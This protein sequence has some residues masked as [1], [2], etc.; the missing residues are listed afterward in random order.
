[1][2]RW[3]AGPTAQAAQLPLPLAPLSTDR[4]RR[5]A[6]TAAARRLAPH[7]PPLLLQPR[8]S[9]AWSRSRSRSTI[10]DDG[11]PAASGRDAGQ[12][13]PSPAAVPPR[14][15]LQTAGRRRRCIHPKS[16]RLERRCLP[17]IRSVRVRARSRSDAERKT[18]AQRGR[19]KLG[20]EKGGSDARDWWWSG[21]RRAVRWR[22]L[23]GKFWEPADMDSNEMAPLDLE[24][25]RR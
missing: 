24:N 22:D 1:M 14:R 23:D 21:W 6:T 20:V 4:K 18:T 12:A 3:W 17:P 19:P 8:G 2:G 13:P 11:R 16:Q 25:F 10:P 9:P 7:A 15:S 5:A